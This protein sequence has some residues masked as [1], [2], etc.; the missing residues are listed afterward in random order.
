VCKN[1]FSACVFD[2]QSEKTEKEKRGME[3]LLEQLE[4]AELLIAF[5]TVCKKVH[6]RYATQVFNYSPVEAHV[7][8]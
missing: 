4:A 6:S 7:S 8:G 3:D 5:A 1:S 2:T